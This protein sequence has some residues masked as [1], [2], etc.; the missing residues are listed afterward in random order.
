MSD[1]PFLMLSR[2]YFEHALWTEPRVFSRAEAWLDCVRLAAW[3]AHRRL[4]G[5]M[6]IEIPRGGIVA[7]E[8]FLSDRWQWS[9][10]KVRSF[11]D[12]LSEDR[13]IIRKKDQGQ[14][15][16]LLCNYERFNTPKDQEKTKE[17]PRRDQGRT[18][19]EEDIK[20]RIS[21]PGEEIAKRSPILPTCSQAME[22]AP[23]VGIDPKAAECWWLDCESRGLSPA[24]FLIDA[25]GAEIRNWVAAMTSY[26]RKWQ[27]NDARHTQP[28]RGA[29]VVEKPKPLPSSEERYGKS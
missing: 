6:M 7:S 5:G 20:E 3:R 10:T 1:D 8:R 27:S 18:K 21:V 16:L 14:T 19:V 4:I 15:L 25:K 9:R 13:M 11:V 12:L 29:A 28:R 22:R 26:G 23:S 2:A 24:G 17:E